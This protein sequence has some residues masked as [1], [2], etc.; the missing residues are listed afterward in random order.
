MLCC[1]FASSSW[2]WRGLSHRPAVSLARRAC[3]SNTCSVRLF[4]TPP[5]PKES[6]GKELL[7]PKSLAIGGSMGVLGGM[8]GVGGGVLAIPMLTSW[9]G[10]TQHQAHGTS[11]AAVMATGS[12][13]TLIP[14]S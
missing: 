11:L 10:T 13:F 5:E 6:K 3:V 1:S 2:M 14:S 12:R 8:A 9:I 7:L 4:V